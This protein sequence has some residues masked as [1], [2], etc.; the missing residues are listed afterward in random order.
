MLTEN[1]VLII[2]CIQGQLEIFH[3]IVVK[4]RTIEPQSWQKPEKLL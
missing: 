4:L 2:S 1:G 3:S